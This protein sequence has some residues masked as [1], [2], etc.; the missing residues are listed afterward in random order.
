VTLGL[1]SLALAVVVWFAVSDAENPPETN[2]FAG[3]IP[4]L[5]VNVPQGKAPTS[6]SQ[7]GQVRVKITADK[8]IWNELSISDF[9][10]TVDLSGVTQTQVNV[11]VLVTV[12]RNDVKVVQVTP[13]SVDV[14]LEPVTTQAKPVKINTVAVA[15]AAIPSPTRRSRRGRC[16]L[17]ARKAWSSRQTRCGST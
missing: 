6:L 13:S 12:L 17:R 7:T 14:V 11:P 9:K 1:L 10:A 4:V 16:R 15:P 8:D 3:S 2:F 5:A